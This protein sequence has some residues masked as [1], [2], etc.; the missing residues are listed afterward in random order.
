MSIIYSRPR[1]RLPKFVYYK[2]K[3][4]ID[5]QKNTRRTKLILIVFIA[6]A[7]LKI[8]IDAVE[9][10]FT[11]LCE[12]KAISLATIISNKKATEVMKEHNYDDFFTIEKNQDGTVSLLKA[13]VVP[14]NQ[15]TS[16]IAVRIQE[17]INNQGRDDV[18]IALRNIYGDE[19]IGRTWADNTY[20]NIYDRKYKHRF[21]KRIF[22]KRNKSNST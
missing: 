11:T 5:N 9:P 17:E 2:N 12:N 18:G 4:R 1:L 3:R 21:K 22:L 14:I 8:V 6:F 19:T 13:N 16:D 15:I 7:T 20:K 10:V